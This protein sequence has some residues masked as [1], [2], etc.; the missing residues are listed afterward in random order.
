LF[1]L[2]LK[3]IVVMKNIKFEKKSKPIM[4]YINW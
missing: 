1:L 3:R 2:N 4:T